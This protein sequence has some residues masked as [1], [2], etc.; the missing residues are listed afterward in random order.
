MSSQPPYGYDP[1]TPQWQGQPQQPEYPP[2]YAHDPSQPQQPGYPPPPA[3]PSQPMYPPPPAYPSQPMY[4]GYP[5]QG[6]GMAAP[7]SVPF[8][9][10]M[11]MAQP[12]QGGG[13]AIAGLVLG[14]IAIP[15]AIFWPCGMLFSA[16]GIVFGALGR[17]SVSRRG[18]ATAGLVCAI[19]GG[20]LAVVFLI[21]SLSVRTNTYSSTY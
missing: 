8:M 7:G 5:P 21:I 6:Y 12:D 11:P 2:A 16:L 3:Y 9:P 19:I 17:R 20:A 4:P 14:I 13:M 18:M 10:G 1:N 15:A